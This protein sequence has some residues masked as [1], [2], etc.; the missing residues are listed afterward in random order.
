[1]PVSVLPIDAASF[2]S[3]FRQHAGG[4]V[5]VTLDNGTGPVGFTATS[6]ASV[7]IDPPMATIAISNTSS[8]WPRLCTAD[9]VVV[10]FLDHDQSE[11]A[12]R[13]ATHGIDRFASP[14]RWHRLGSAEPVLDDARRWMRAAVRDRIPVGDHHVV[15]LEMLEV[16]VTGDTGSALVYHRGNYHPIGHL[17]A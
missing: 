9:S 13:F 7:S 5:V 8:T 11:L 4:V 17:N 2:R 15:V 16:E 14:T 12:G 1:M 6:L 3:L 10:N